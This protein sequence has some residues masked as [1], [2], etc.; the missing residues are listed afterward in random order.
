MTTRNEL[1]ALAAEHGAEIVGGNVAARI[2]GEVVWLGKM[3]EGTFSLTDAGV[4]F[5]QGL[6]EKPKAAA[7]PRTKAKVAEV[8]DAPNLD[9]VLGE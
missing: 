4:E 3:N 2:N 7:K 5:V 8:T 6:E 9:D 1:L